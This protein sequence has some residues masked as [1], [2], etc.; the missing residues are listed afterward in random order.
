MTGY[1]VR[2][3]EVGLD[4]GHGQSPGGTGRLF[5]DATL[6]SMDGSMLR[7]DSYRRD[8][9]LVILMLGDGGLDDRCAALLK[10][11]ADL[12]AELEMEE[13]RVIVIAAGAREEW[14]GEWPYPFSLAFDTDAQLHRQLAAINDSG[15]PE[16]L[17]CITD[18]YREIFAMAR[19]GDEQWPARGMQVIE[20]LTF[21][22]I[23]C[24]ECSAPEAWS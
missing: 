21:V 7:L 4:A 22:N 16:V 1:D 13:A 12:R 18:R 11:L 8:W 23:Q 14:V 2:E 17:L 15:R 9:N 10:E 3:S 20:W 24:P 5:P 19:V 6:P